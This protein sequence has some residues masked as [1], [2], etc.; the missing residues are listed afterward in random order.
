MLAGAAATALAFPWTEDMVRGR[1]VRP[2]TEMLTPP[3]G[4][5]AIGHRR[6]LDRD[7][8]DKRLTNPLAAS[9]EVLEQGRAL[10]GTY[11]AVCHGANGQ[12]GGPVGKYFRQVA[13]LAG[14]AVQGY[15]DGLMYSV[16]REGG[17]NMPGYAETLS[18]PERWAVV[19]LIRTFR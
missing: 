5:L 10:F 12:G 11:C 15:S 17:F 19:H 7:D 18:V 6:I 14:P 2:Q 13:D 9:T 3:P 4:T 8:A 16:I 1:A